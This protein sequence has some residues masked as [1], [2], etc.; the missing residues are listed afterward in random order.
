MQTIDLNSNQIECSKGHI[1]VK[2]IIPDSVEKSDSGIVI[3]TVKQ[4]IENTRPC[5][6]VVVTSFVAGIKSGDTVI[7]P[8]SDGIDVKFKDGQYLFLKASSIIAR[9][10][11]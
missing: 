3:R 6:G 11:S 4:G 5:Y 1:L 10:D 7:F 8:S 2:P 9:A